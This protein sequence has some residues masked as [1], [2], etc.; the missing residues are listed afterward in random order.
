MKEKSKSKNQRGRPVVHDIT[1]LNK[2][3]PARP[4]E[5]AK[6]LFSVPIKPK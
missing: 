4:E 1:K 2:T 5:L 3:I 6:A